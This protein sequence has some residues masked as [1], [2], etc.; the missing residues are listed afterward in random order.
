MEE[1]D[2]LLLELQS[3]DTD[4][5]A[6][7]E[8]LADSLDSRVVP[9]FLRLLLDRSEDEL[10]RVEI[11]KALVVRRDNDVDRSC[12]SS[13]VCSILERDDDTLVRQFAA[14]AMSRFVEV[15]GALQ[16]LESLITD[17]AEDIDVRHNALAAIEANA[18]QKICQDA[19]QRLVS[20][21]ELGRSAA[22]ILQ[23]FRT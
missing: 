15:N 14:K 16:L 5:C 22:R 21:P 23:R 2:T 4:R 13:A 1:I 8:F 3:N 9:L 11:L 6:I 7:I 10:V 19:L 12:L 17:V 20:V 18:S